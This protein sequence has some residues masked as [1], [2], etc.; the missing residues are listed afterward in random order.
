MEPCAD[1]VWSEQRPALPGGVQ[2]HIDH[3]GPQSVTVAAR[4][5]VGLNLKELQQAGP[6]V[7]GGHGHQRAALA[8]QH[9]A[10]GAHIEQ[11]DTAGGQDLQEVDD[12]EVINQGVRQLYKG[13]RETLFPVHCHASQPSHRVTGAG[14]RAQFGGWRGLSASILVKSHPARH[15]GGGHICQAAAL[16]EGMGA[17]P[18]Q[19]LCLTHLKLG[20]DHPGGL[21]HLGPVP[22]PLIG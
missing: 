19:R 8:G 6:L 15:H 18:D 7:G 22:G 5:L 11:L 10:D 4:S 21:M 16:A 13:F 3:R 17:H 2:V 1:C 14:P 12:I 20:A 9:D